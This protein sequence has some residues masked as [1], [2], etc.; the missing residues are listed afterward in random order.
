MVN[1]VQT[2]TNL[3]APTKLRFDGHHSLNTWLFLPL[4][5]MLRYLG[6]LRFMSCLLDDETILSTNYSLLLRKWIVM[7]SLLIQQ[8]DFPS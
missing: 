6:S 5:E 2:P 8:H 7:T 1:H 3:M 4:D